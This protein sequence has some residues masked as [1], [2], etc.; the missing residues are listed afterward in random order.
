LGIN[1]VVTCR[2]FVEFLLQ[3]L[4][5]ELSSSR[6]GLFDAHLSECP[7]CVAYLQ[8]YAE[9][10]KFGKAALMATKEPVPDEVPDELIEAILAARETA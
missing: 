2:E 10:I 8:N 7:W 3:Y 5:G 4:E 6:R 9:T 1:Q